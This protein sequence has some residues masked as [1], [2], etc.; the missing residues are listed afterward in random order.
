[1]VFGVVAYLSGKSAAAL[2][3]AKI[4]DK[5]NLSLSIREEK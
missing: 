3:A 4:D 5:L 1:M 2:A